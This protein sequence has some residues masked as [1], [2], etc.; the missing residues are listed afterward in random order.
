M[1]RPSFCL[2]VCLF[3]LTC[4]CLQADPAPGLVP[5]GIPACMYRD[6]RST[7][8]FTGP[9]GLAVSATLD[10]RPLADVVIT[11]D[12]AE[13]NLRLPGPG[14]L[15]IIGGEQQFRW[16]VLAPEENARLE[17]RQ[18]ALFTTEGMPVLLLARHFQPP[19]LDRTW[20]TLLVM[21]RLWRDT[22]PALARLQVVGAAWL[23]PAE[24]ALMGEVDDVPVAFWHFFPPSDAVYEVSGLVPQLLQ[25]TP[26]PGWMLA[27][28][29]TD[30]ERGLSP[31]EWRMQWEFA[32]QALAAR[33]V[34]P[35]FLL[36]PPVS[37]RLQRR[38]PTAL[39]DL[40]LAAQANHAV[41]LNAFLERQTSGITA[42]LLSDQVMPRLQP[43]L[44]VQP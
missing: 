28:G 25:E 29:T 15:R 23:P 6:E 12:R 2:P 17:L 19:P 34:G 11:R 36:A 4:L 1:N 13:L 10:D 44:R 16:R 26:A 42:Q 32:L 18:G 40:R 33:K 21:Q 38:F 27:P 31:T 9:N 37:S 41:F 39:A 30:L 35:V 8:V 22:R 5:A 7:L 14:V 20:E 24:R 3:L 43:Y